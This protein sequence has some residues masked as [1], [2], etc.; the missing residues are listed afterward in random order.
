MKG[1]GDRILSDWLENGCGDNSCIVAKP[2]GQATN[3]GCRCPEAVIRVKL[4]NTNVARLDSEI[5]ALKTH[6]EELEAECPTCCV[7]YDECKK[8]GHVCRT[9]P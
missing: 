3:G 7:L 5:V 2:H 6:I 1:C 8:N 9:K 4:M